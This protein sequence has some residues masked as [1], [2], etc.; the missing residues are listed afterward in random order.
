MFDRRSAFGS[1]VQTPCGPRK[2]GMPESVE[3]PAPVNATIRLDAPTH[4]QTIPIASLMSSSQDAPELQKL[5]W[6]PNLKSRP[7][8]I[9]VGVSQNGPYRVFTPRIGLALSRL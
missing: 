2:S 8:R 9:C 5:T 6:A 1:F 3:M 7:G 4:L